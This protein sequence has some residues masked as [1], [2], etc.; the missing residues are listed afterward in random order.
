MNAVGQISS[1]NIVISAFFSTIYLACAMPDPSMLNHA[2]DSLKRIKD[3]KPVQTNSFSFDNS[4]STIFYLT[5]L[6][7]FISVTTHTRIIEAE[8]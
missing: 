5:V 3:L 8:N 1:M 6:T 7:K 4:M 2:F